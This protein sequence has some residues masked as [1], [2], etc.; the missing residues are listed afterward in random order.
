MLFL[1]FLNVMHFFSPG[2]LFCFSA[3]VVLVA[4]RL[5]LGWG[6]HSSCGAQ[7]SR[8]RGF[9]CCGA[10]ALDTQASVAAACRL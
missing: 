1:V 8:C 4:R 5:C 2:D 7:A 3:V 6:L 9:S 10:W